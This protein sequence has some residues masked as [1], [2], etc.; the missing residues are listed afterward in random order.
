MATG[1]GRPW[2]NA[3]V[4][5]RTGVVVDTSG[6]AFQSLAREQDAFLQ[7]L[8]VTIA[9]VVAIYGLL[10]EPTITTYTDWP[11]Y[12]N[13]ST[14]PS[15]NSSSTPRAPSFVVVTFVVVG[16]VIA[17]IC[18]SLVLRARSKKQ[19]GRRQLQI[20]LIR[21]DAGNRRG[22]ATEQEAWETTRVEVDESLPTYT[23]RGTPKIAAEL[24]PTYNDLPLTSPRP[25]T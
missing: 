2:I 15:Q 20:P 19:D 24:P 1:R 10:D 16:V 7:C 22:N 17:T 8:N 13:W 5:S 6:P 12:T 14:S 18:G 9:G 25:A 3:A 4:S 21:Q 23:P 11:T